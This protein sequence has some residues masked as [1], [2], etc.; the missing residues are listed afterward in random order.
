[1]C[2][3]R[4]GEV[5]ATDLEEG[6]AGTTLVTEDRGSFILGPEAEAALLEAIEEADRGDFISETSSSGSF[7]EVELTSPILFVHRLIP[8]PSHTANPAT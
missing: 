7:A 1:M 8:A 5:V 6:T 2:H 4:V 3:E